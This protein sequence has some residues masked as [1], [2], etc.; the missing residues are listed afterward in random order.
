MPNPPLDYTRIYDVLGQCGLVPVHGR[1][2]EVG[3]V[4][5]APG[6]DSHLSHS[7]SVAIDV[8]RGLIDEED[9]IEAI[10]ASGI[11]KNVVLAKL[12]ATDGA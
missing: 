11:D 10:E 3:L 8:S 4:I 5:F 12:A 6:P 7:Q 1:D 9:F 2:E